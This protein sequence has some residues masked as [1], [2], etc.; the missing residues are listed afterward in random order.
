MER[1]GID[2]LARK[3]V[4]ELSGG[5]QQRTFVAQGLAQQAELLLLDEPITGLDV[6]SQQLIEQVLDEETEEGNTVV[7]TTHDVRAA[8]RAAHVLL[9]A[10]HVVAEGPPEKVLTEEHL[11]HAFGGPAFRTPDGALIITDPHV[12]GTKISGHEDHEG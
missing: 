12:H 7:M 2:G 3:Q 11:G 9:L 8:G 5:Q 1:M 4:R 6:P 10:T